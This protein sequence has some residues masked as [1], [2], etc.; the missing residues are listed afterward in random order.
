MQEEGPVREEVFEIK[1]QYKNLKSLMEDEGYNEKDINE[2]LNEE[3][4]R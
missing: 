4:K 2:A 1:A 3:K